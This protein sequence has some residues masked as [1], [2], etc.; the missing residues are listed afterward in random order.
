MLFY[1]LKE[2]L[3]TIFEQNKITILS[4]K[5]YKNNYDFSFL[6]KLKK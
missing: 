6:N 3:I 4:D 2:Q 1:N 5:K